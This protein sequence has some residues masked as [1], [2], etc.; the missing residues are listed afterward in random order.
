MRSAIRCS[1]ASLHWK[2][3]ICTV[4]PSRGVQCQRAGSSQ[5]TVIF[6]CVWYFFLVVLGLPLLFVRVMFCRVKSAACMWNA[7]WQRV[8]GQYF[9]PCFDCFCLCKLPGLVLP[10]H[11]N[12]QGVISVSLWSILAKIGC[13]CLCKWKDILDVWSGQ[14][15]DVAGILI[16]REPHYDQANNLWSLVMVSA[17]A[18][19]NIWCGWRK[20]THL[21]F[22]NMSWHIGRSYMLTSCTHTHTYMLCIHHHY[23]TCIYA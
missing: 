10:V 23:H 7:C 12:V 22:L 19:T 1:P 20:T 16:E 17:R 11:T 18:S 14:T 13:I 5:D 21:I 4:V 6:R 3:S 15:S 9:S 8:A 2:R